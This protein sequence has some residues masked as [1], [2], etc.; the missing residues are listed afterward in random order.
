MLYIL[1]FKTF[2]ATINLFILVF[3]GIRSSLRVAA[4]ALVKNGRVM[5]VQLAEVRRGC[6]CGGY[7]LVLYRGA[8]AQYLAAVEEDWRSQGYMMHA[9]AARILIYRHFLVIL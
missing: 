2:N 8:R 5:R 7:G 1:L 9:D 6:P 3:F 4:Q